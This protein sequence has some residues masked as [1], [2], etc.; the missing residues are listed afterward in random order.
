MV[1]ATN[2]NYI[3]CVYKE[4]FVKNES[5]RKTQHIHKFRKL[6][7]TYDSDRKKNQFNSKQIIWILKPYSLLKILE[8]GINV[9][10]SNFQIIKNKN[11]YEISTIYE[12]VEKLSMIML[13]DLFGIQL[14]FF[15]N[16]VE[17]CNFLNLY[18]LWTLRSSV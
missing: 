10:K 9:L 5:Y 17:Y 2:L 16:R 18:G 1:I 11:Y 7:A 6:Q 12:C 15:T 4:K 13:Y 14:I 8:T 3:C